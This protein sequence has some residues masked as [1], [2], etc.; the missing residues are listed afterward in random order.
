MSNEKYQLTPKGF[1]RVETM[2][3]MTEK[4]F[5]DMWERFV[6]F[7]ERNGFVEQVGEGGIDE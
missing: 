1:L 3:Y 5:E 4:Q 7:M 6:D 2:P